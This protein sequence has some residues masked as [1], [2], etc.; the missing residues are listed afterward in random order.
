MEM[1]TNLL[2]EIEDII[3]KLNE[4]REAEGRTEK[5]RLLSIAITNLETAKLYIKESATK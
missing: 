3:A 5:A 1:A 2:A 4:Q